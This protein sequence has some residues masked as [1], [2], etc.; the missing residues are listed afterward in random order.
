MKANLLREK[1]TEVGMFQP[2]CFN[3]IITDLSFI[4]IYIYIY[5]LQSG[6]NEISSNR[7]Q[8]DENA[9]MRAVAKIFRAREREHPCNFCQQFKQ[10]PNF[11]SS[12][13]LNGTIRYPLKL[14][15]NSFSRMFM[16][17]SLSNFFGSQILARNEYK[18]F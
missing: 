4:Y 13:K 17:L 15:A 14:H 11:V 10:R 9:S 16:P 2:F 6:I 12:F 1:V 7:A 3:H 5:I 8:V 18:S